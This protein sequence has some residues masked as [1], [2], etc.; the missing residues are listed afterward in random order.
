M[1]IV[2]QT[3]QKTVGLATQKITL[4]QMSEDFL[5]TKSFSP[6]NLTNLSVQMS[7]SLLASFL[8]SATLN[9]TKSHTACT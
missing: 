8:K 5:P 6:P 2:Q 4:D 3:S 9:I 1:Y 7:D